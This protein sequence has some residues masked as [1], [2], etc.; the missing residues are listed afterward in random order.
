MYILEVKENHTGSKIRLI[1][2]P[3]TNKFN[4]CI[5]Y[6]KYNYI[7]VNLYYIC[8]FF[9]LFNP[10]EPVKSFCCERTKKKINKRIN[11]MLRTALFYLYL[12]S[13]TTNLFL[14][15]KR[16]FVPCTKKIF[17]RCKGKAKMK[18]NHV[19]NFIYFS[20]GPFKHTF[21]PIGLI[22]I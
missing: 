5:R 3:V 11:F 2:I 8:E 6:K 18:T 1:S 22:I 7:E 14:L 21:R 20:G 17:V 4:T 15:F 12:F 16:Y 9:C 10:S 13:P 19:P